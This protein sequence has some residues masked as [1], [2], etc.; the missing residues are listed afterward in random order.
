L[1][2]QFLIALFYI[3]FEFLPD[4]TLLG[5]TH[6]HFGEAVVNRVH[7]GLSG[8]APNAH[9][10]NPYKTI[11][12]PSFHIHFCRFDLRVHIKKHP[13]IRRALTRQTASA[14]LTLRL[15]FIMNASD[16]GIITGFY[17]PCCR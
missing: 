15:L 17:L 12:H 9:Q 16:V 3:S 11:E 13:P 5:I 10:A 8:A 2:S 1:L 7:I 14:D 6:F 4:L